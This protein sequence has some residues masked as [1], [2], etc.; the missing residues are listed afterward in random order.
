MGEHIFDVP[1]LPVETTER[2]HGGVAGAVALFNQA[3]TSIDPGFELAPYVDDVTTICRT[4]DGLPLAVELAASHIRTLPPPLLRTRLSAQLG[5]AT[6]AARDLPGRQR[7][8]PATIDWS[9]QLLG[10]AERELF[11]QLGV[12]RD[13]SRSK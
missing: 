9:L 2:N 10:E 4:V 6:S 5:T 7:T 13:R 1:P 11:V 3:A 12:S 8:I